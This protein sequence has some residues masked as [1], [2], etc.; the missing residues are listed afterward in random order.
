[1]APGSK[2]ALLK[3]IVFLIILFLKTDFDVFM[4]NLLYF[5]LLRF[6]LGFENNLTTNMTERSSKILQTTICEEQ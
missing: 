3:I 6:S 4:R 1:M 2:E 5:S